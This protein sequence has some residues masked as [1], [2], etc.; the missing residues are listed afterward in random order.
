MFLANV[1]KMEIAIDEFEKEIRIITNNID[2]I[3]FIIQSLKKNS[4]L[5]DIIYNLS[6]SKEKLEK[7]RTYFLKMF[8]VLNEIKRAYTKCEKCIL[9]REE[10]IKNSVSNRIKLVSLNDKEGYVQK[11][12]IYL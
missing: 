1:I 3:E 10:G 7:N 6:K 8:G 4:G 5:D 2:E 9:E 12:N 11:F